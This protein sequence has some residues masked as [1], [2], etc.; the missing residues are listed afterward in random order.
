MEATVSVK[1]GRMLAYQERGPRN[2]F[3]VFLLHGTPGGRNGPVP[4][5]I[6]LDLL[7]VRLISYDRPGYGDSGRHYG[8]RVSDAAAD[9]EAIAD[10][11]RLGP[12]GVVGRSGG[13]PHALACAALL[14]S[15]VC[16]V[17]VLVSLAP[18]DANDLDWYEGMND[19]NRDAY[20]RANNSADI[21]ADSDESES[22]LLR[23]I[24]FWT[25]QDQKDPDDLLQRLQPDLGKTDRHVVDDPALRRLLRESYSSA[26]RPGPGGW[27]DDVL[28]FRRPW[29]FELSDVYAQ[30]LLW[31]GEQ[32][33]FSPVHHTRWLAK[34][35][36]YA[37]VQIQQD[38]GHFTAFEALPRILGWITST[39]SQPLEG[40]L[41]SLGRG[42]A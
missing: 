28:A 8:R 32:D 35:L 2:G 3:P 21:V 39:M 40:K 1:D 16:K 26:L 30:T 37:T 36:P 13:G 17:A 12:F 25:E 24:A 29:G 42:P 27:H 34:Q 5:D 18:S 33:G 31:H 22:D 4:R 15:R 14:G 38:A 19:T 20:S 23:S 41:A 10:E 6:I 9:V 7:G 11:L